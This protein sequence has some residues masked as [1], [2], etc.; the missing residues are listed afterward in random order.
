MKVATSL[1][2]LAIVAR[3]LCVTVT[4]PA[5][6]PFYAAP[7]NI[8][9]YKPGDIIRHRNLPNPA[10]GITGLEA[11]YQLL[12]RTTDSLGNPEAA[13]TTILVPK[14]AGSNKLL[15]YQ[16]AEDAAAVQCAPSVAIQQ[17]S[18]DTSYQTLL[19]QGVVVN[20]PDYEGPKSVF[21]AGVQAGQAT[22]DSIR[23]SLQSKDLTGLSEDANVAMWGYSGGSIASG[24]A[25]QLQD[26]YAPDLNDNV[27]GVAVGGFVTNLTATALLVNKTPYVGFLPAA[28]LSLATAY[29]LEDLIND[30]LIPATADEF[31]QAQSQCM[32]ADLA[33]FAGQDLFTYFKDG[34]GALYL[35]QVQAVLQKLTMGKMAPKAPLFVYQGEQDQIAPV[36]SVDETISEYCAAGAAVNYYKDPNTEHLGT[37]SNGIP[38]AI[39]F[40]EDVLGGSS[41]APGCTTVITVLGSDQAGTTEVDTGAPHPA[42]SSGA[43]VS[44]TTSIIFTSA[45]G[46]LSF[47]TTTTV[48]SGTPSATGIVTTGTGSA[49]PGHMTSAPFA[50]N[51]TAIATGSAASSVPKGATYTLTTTDN[52]T[53]ETKTIT[54]TDCSCTKTPET[55]AAVETSAPAPAVTSSIKYITTTDSITGETITV[56]DCSCTKTP[57]GAVSTPTGSASGNGGNGGNGGNS[58]QESAAA[59]VS[60]P[61]KSGSVEQSNSGLT[62]VAPL[63]L[64][65]L[66]AGALLL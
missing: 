4:S 61:T 43:D 17:P 63:G 55:T 46:P 9:D 6:D 56:E 42:T 48:I 64:S 65:L 30:E 60:S 11:S 10:V 62:L 14:N 12:Y 47:G 54:V 45:S 8:T 26:S 31:K 5:S 25:A 32:I 22:L 44:A 40:V 34:M 58:G 49:A 29:N 20:I 59:E 28:L 66:A 24:W 52:E 36:G 38:Y 13:V 23:A 1:S 50:G 19:D 39:K 51:G 16:I 21:S 33:Q 3:A 53:G 41:V 18:F 15:S 35:P 2:F 7:S 27:K 37:A 57:T